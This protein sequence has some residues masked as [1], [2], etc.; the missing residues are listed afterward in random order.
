MPFKGELESTIQYLAAQPVIPTSRTNFLRPDSQILTAR[1][2]DIITSRVE[3]GFNGR[4]ADAI[5]IVSL[6]GIAGGGPATQ[7]LQAAQT[8]EYLKGNTEYSPEIGLI[9]QRSEL[10]YFADNLTGKAPELIAEAE[11]KTS[12]PEK[13]Q[14]AE[15]VIIEALDRMTE[16]GKH[17]IVFVSNGYTAFVPFAVKESFIKTGADKKG[18]RAKVVIFDSSFPDSS[19]PIDIIDSGIGYPTD[20]FFPPAFKSTPNADMYLLLCNWMPINVKWYRDR[21]PQ[22]AMAISTS[23]P[24]SFEYVKRWREINQLT[25]EQARNEII[26]DTNI[27]VNFRKILANHQTIYFPLITS[28]GYWDANNVGKWMT[29]IQYKDMINGSRTITHAAA[30]VARS[31]NRPVLLT[32][33]KPFVDLAKL[34]AQE[35]VIEDIYHITEE[36][37]ISA[38]LKRGVYLMEIPRFK[39]ST[40]RFVIKSAD[41]CLFRSTQTNTMGEAVLAGVPGLVI[42]MPRHGYMDAAR[43]DEEFYIRGG[44]V[45]GPEDSHL[46]IADRLEAI[47][48]DSNESLSL[49]ERQ[50][51]LFREVYRNSGSNFVTVMSHICGI[52]Y[53]D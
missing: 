33:V 22:G 36:D 52:P 14:A 46:K 11:E 23:L 39:Q 40:Y 27:P 42:S 4:P 20:R 53:W 9:S 45:Y 5:L 28:A 15:K 38:S 32:G 25:K 13:Y 21:A 41:V 35:D 8:M 19:N 29:S 7:T 50:L 34:Y 44:R 48:S 17:E 30:Q 26:G 3:F 18:I 24:F 6:G 43:M 16:L 2:T 37:K 10:P 49:A 31:A 47:A 51:S 1:D 12:I